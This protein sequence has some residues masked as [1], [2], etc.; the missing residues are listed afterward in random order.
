MQWWLFVAALLLTLALTV[1]AKISDERLQ[2]PD[3]LPAT[4]VQRN[5]PEVDVY[6][7]AYSSILQRKTRWEV[8]S[9]M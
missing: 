9:C 7:S 2:Q 8:K 3:P 4:S 6:S 5:V 1:V